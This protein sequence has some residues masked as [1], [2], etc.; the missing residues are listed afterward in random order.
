MSLLVTSY[1]FLQSFLDLR[2]DLVR[3]Q[4]VLTQHVGSLAGLT[5]PVVD[6]DLAEF[7]ADLAHQYIGHSV[8]QTSDDAVLLHGNDIAALFGV[9]RHAL[10][11]NGLDGV[12]VDDADLDTLGGEQLGGL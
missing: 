4:A 7:A 6:A 3:R 10:R 9:L 8:T 1:L 2:R 12:Y 5:E 11:V